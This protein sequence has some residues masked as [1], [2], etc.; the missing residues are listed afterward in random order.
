MPS[1][2]LVHPAVWP[3][4]ILTENWRAVPLEGSGVGSPFN[5]M[6]RRPRPT[7]EAY[8]RTKWHLDPCSRLATI[9]VGLKLGGL[10]PFWGWGLGSV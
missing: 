4:R 6:S 9:D 2:I 8:L 5:T 7:A 3:Q 1:G 10:R